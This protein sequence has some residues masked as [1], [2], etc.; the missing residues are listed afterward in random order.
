MVF[1]AD[2][3]KEFEMSTIAVQ[4]TEQGILL[5]RA[6]YQDWGD[7]EV[8]REEQRII[9]RPKAATVRQERELA[10][11]ALREDGLLA[12]LNWEATYPP[13]SL[14]ERAELAKKL[15]AGRPLSEIIIE[16]REAGW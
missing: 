4:I 5:P 1:E 13:T 15:S 9:I 14:E 10:V 3:R 7:V 6:A 16:E 2:S 12:T 11:Q 8:I